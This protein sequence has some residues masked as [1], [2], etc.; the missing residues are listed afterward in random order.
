ML[1][2]FELVFAG[3]NSQEDSDVAPVVRESMY[4][5]MPHSTHALVPASILYLPAEQ[6]THVPSVEIECPGL[7]E[8]AEGEELPAGEEVDAGHLSQVLDDVEPTAVENVPTGQSLHSAM[9]GSLLNLPARHCVHGPPTGPLDPA[10]QR[11]LISEAAAMLQ[12][13]SKPGAVTEPSDLNTILSVPV[14]ETNSVSGGTL[15]PESE[16]SRQPS[17]AFAQS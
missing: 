3:H 17:I 6:A 2:G 8:Q 13:A 12:A 4:L 9:S 7:H 10:L 5:P 14:D 11:H 16:S 1:D 15:L